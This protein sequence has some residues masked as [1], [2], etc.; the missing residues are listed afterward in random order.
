MNHTRIFLKE[1]FASETGTYGTHANGCSVAVY[2]KS[3][4]N[5]RWGVTT[6][7][8]GQRIVHKHPLTP[9]KDQTQAQVMGFF[10]FCERTPHL[11]AAFPFICTIPDRVLLPGSEAS[12]FVLRFVGHDACAPPT[13]SNFFSSS[14]SNAWLLEYFPC[15][16]RF[17]R[18]I[19]DLKRKKMLL[20]LHSCLSFFLFFFFFFFTSRK[21]YCCLV[22][23]SQKTTAAIF[24]NPF[25]LLS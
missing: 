20:V 2:L 12:D 24:R 19:I 16:S 13:L 5:R 3:L 14:P 21:R 7:L 25:L 17:R 1:K 8:T 4:R 9:D 11:G 18:V 23:R 10:Y 6:F 15:M 22:L